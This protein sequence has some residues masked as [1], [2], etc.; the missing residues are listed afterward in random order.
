MWKLLDVTDR[1][2]KWD[3]LICISQLNT[4]SDYVFTITIEYIARLSPRT[5]SLMLSYDDKGD[6][7]FVI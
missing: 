6:S 3:K 7:E 2:Y 5:L 4:P 1:N